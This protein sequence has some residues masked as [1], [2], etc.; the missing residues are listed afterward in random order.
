[1]A[2]GG[3]VSSFG[4]PLVD[5]EVVVEQELVLGEQ[6]LGELEASQTG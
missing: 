5:L 3:G 2:V 1:M 6:Q 4:G